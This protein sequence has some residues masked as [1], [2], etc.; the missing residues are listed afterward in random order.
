MAAV[1]APLALGVAA[2]TDPRERELLV[3]DTHGRTVTRADLP[4]DGR[5][6][7]AYMHSVYRAPAR[8]RFVAGGEG[9]QLDSIASPKNEVLDYY[10]LAGRRARRGRWRILEPR[11]KRRYSEL[12]LIA[13]RVGR[14]TLLAG[15]RRIPLYGRRDRHLRVTLGGGR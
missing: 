7:L 13:T 1:A 9:F 11:A 15:G 14:R 4:G 8:E 12:A 10:A 5:F 3:R 2:L 6:E